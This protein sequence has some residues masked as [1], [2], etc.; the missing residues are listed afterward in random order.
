MYTTWL[1]VLYYTQ[2]NV[3]F[4]YLV[5]NNSSVNFNYELSFVHYEL[6]CIIFAIYKFVIH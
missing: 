6:N 4:T 5:T 3:S 2:I 1:W